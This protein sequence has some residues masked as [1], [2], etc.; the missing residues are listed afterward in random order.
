M[1][2]L[3]R[4]LFHTLKNLSRQ[5]GLSL[6]E[7]TR[8]IIMG[9][10]GRDFHNFNVHYRNNKQYRVLAFTAT[11]IPG[12]EERDYPPELA[13]PDYPNGIPIHPEEE[14]PQLIKQHNADEV[15][16]AYSDVSHEYVMHKASWVLSLGPDFRL[17]GP[18]TTMLKSKV[19]VV[20]VCA[21]RT[22]SGKSQTS[23]KVALILKKMGLRVAVIR[24][25]MPYGDLAKQVWQRFAS[26]EDLNRH[27][28]TIEEREEYEPH[29]ANGIVVFAGVDYEKIL[30][31][32]EKEAD[33]VVW[34]GGNND[35][36]FYQPD[37]HIVV[38]DPHRPGHELTYY[39]GETNLRMAN[40]IVIN[41][42]DTASPEGIETV[43]KNIKTVNPN[44]LII[45]AA[46]PITV[47]NPGMIKG[48]RVLVVEDGPTLTHGN[49]AYGAGVIAARRLGA[50]EIIDP[51]P[52]AVGS[53]EKT[54]NKYP[55]LGTL[56]PAVGYGK[57]QVKELE[58]TINKTPCDVVLI[59]TPIDL[60]RVLQINKPA[61]SAQYNLEELGS[62]TLEDVL[63]KLLQ[64]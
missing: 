1:R 53:I 2:L 32:A 56:L 5:G 55:H 63:K 16:F 27:E 51:R 21:V 43:Q 24:H 36:A 19:P 22:G 14:L 46:S 48:K 9:A 47:D 17:M 38:V 28:C 4:I 44:A 7:K 54:F 26:Y 58:M 49:M 60:R 23:R 10:A 8:V 57:E 6:M 12:I 33:V 39:P 59:G 34:D 13:G 3:E 15:V 37:L 29:I 52:Y 62:P 45:R 40:I 61:V 18:H 64:K 25:P 11:Q 30:R 35:L 31:E 20:S 42:V 50:A 41:K